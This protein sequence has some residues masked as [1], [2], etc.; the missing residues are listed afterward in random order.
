ME[1][2]NSLNFKFIFIFIVTLK[3]LLES[4]LVF[5]NISSIKRNKERIPSRFKDI[6]TN[7]EYSRAVNYNISKLRFQIVSSFTSSALLLLITLGG[8]LSLLTKIA[9]ETTSSNVIGAILLGVLFIIFSEIVGMPFSIYSIFFLE[10]KYGFNKTTVK[11][12][13]LDTI[14]QFILSVILISIIFSIIVIIIQY[15]VSFWWLYAFIAVFIFQVILFFVYPTLIAPLF[16]KFEDLSDERFKEPI[17]KLLEKVE[18]ESKGLLVMNASLRSTHGNAF[19]TGFGKNKRIVFF[20]TLLKTITPNEM[21][22][23]LGHEL[24]HSKLGHIREG[25]VITTLFSFFSFYIL[26]WVFSSDNFF[27]AHGLT[28][29]TIFSK[30]LMF[31]LVASSYVFFIRPV[32]SYLSRKREFQADDFSLKYTNAEHMI[33]GLLKLSKD[34][35]SNLTPDPMYSGYYYSHPPIAER[36][37]SLEEKF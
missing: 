12:F 33:S 5:R 36:I 16:N 26:G 14:K 7:Q 17:E 27:T 2:F 9:T 10:A 15:F 30:I 28:E 18:F 25:F 6:V 20:D 8:L 4:Y 13:I 34:N 35:A 11:T 1:F 23:I 24:G 31:Y 3:L 19:F 21:E 22:A 37:K 29:L 32:S